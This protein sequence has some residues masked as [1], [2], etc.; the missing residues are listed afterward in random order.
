ML[1]IALSMDAAAVSIANG[2]CFN[3]VRLKTCVPISFS[4]ALFQAIMPIIGFLASFAF[5]SFISYIDHLI[6]FV[7]LTLIGVK[8][9][10][11]S[12]KSE[13]NQYAC[14]KL[15]FKTV[16]VQSIA[17]SIDALAVGVS[18]AALSVPLLKASS[19]IFVVTFLITL[20]A[21]FVG[22]K[23]TRFL[24]F[25]AELLGGIMLILIAL[26]IIVEHIIKY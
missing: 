5:S 18:F 12:L 20:V 17:T 8:M 4:F 7:L 2:I 23:L 14:F 22:K 11:S 3:K 13:K 19:I 10:I 9:I 6:A 26:K 24:K 21:A 15:S 16:I 1:G 25:K